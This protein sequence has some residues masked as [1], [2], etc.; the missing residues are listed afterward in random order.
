VPMIA[1]GSGLATG[2]RLGPGAQR[3]TARTTWTGSW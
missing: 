2:S 1:P 3:G